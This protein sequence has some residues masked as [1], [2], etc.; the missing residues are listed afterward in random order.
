MAGRFIKS[1]YEADNDAVFNI[2]VQPETV[3]D[4]NLEPVGAV[5]QSRYAR[6]TGSRRAYGLKA[7]SMTLARSVGDDTDYNGATVYAR[8]PV[9]KKASVA[10][11]VIGSTITY[12]DV[13]W[14]IVSINPES[15][16]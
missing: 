5:T 10:A 4:E 13:A 7:R 1:K 3:F 8:V 12:Q 6:V 2:R 16:R 14:T 9:L 15:S 11:L